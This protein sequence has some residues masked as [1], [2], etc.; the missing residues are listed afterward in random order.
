M[1][2]AADVVLAHRLA[3]AAGAEILPHFRRLDGVEIKDDAT[4]VTIADRAAERA[5]RTLLASAA[6][7]DGILG[8]ELG[9]VAG[10]NQRLWVLDPI[11]GTRAFVAGKPIFTTLVALVEDGRPR[12][13]VIDQPYLRE[14]WIGDGT[15]AWLNGRPLQTRRSTVLAEAILSCTA[16][17]MFATAADRAGFERLRQSVA[18]TSWGGDAY[19][20]A[21]LAAGTIDLVVEMGLKVVDLA[22]LAPIIEGAGGKV[23]DWGGRPLGLEGDGRVCAA[24]TDTLHAAALACLAG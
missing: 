10:T 21:L 20:F 4:P 18:Q 5:M 3:D 23:T 12:L 16:P 15:A 9:A 7:D 17:E 8:E 19:G 24:A 13:G 1:I 2:A 14:R 6:P 22:P 11:D